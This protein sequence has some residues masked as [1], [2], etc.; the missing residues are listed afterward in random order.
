MEKLKLFKNLNKQGGFTL[1]ELVISVG[2][3]TI[4]MGIASGGFIQAMRNQRMIISLMA[5]NDG[6]SLT[7]EQMAREIRTGYNFCTKNY[8]ITTFSECSSLDNS[9]IQF[10]NAKN[11]VVRY[12]LINGGIE[13]GVGEAIGGGFIYNKITADNVDVKNLNF[14]LLGNN[15]DDGYPPRIT[16]G[17]SFSSNSPDVKK[18]N[19]SIDAQTTISARNIDT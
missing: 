5:I 10:V 14:R 7:L 15:A 1:A 17:V 9:E 6:M 12:K 3:F 18:L 16:V 19:I 4:L 11:Q 8:P 13:K 2:L